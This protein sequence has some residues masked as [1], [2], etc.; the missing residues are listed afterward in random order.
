METAVLS[1]RLDIE[2]NSEDREE[3]GM[4]CTALFSLDLN[5]RMK[6]KAEKTAVDIQDGRKPEDALAI[7]RQKTRWFSLPGDTR[8]SNGLRRYI[9]RTR[10]LYHL[11]TTF[12]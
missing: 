5:R 12:S 8:P 2:E 1:L 9:K 3:V 4:R 7:K 10:T 6:T 11:L